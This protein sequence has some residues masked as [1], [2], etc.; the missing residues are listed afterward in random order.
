MNRTARVKA[1]RASEGKK[2]GSTFSRKLNENVL[3]ASS[4]GKS[5]KSSRKKPQNALALARALCV[6]ANG[7]LAQQ[8]AETPEEVRRQR[9]WWDAACDLLAA[10]GSR[11]ERTVADQVMDAVRGFSESQ[12]I[13]QACDR[14]A[15]QLGLA[16]RN[17]EA[18]APFLVERR[19]DDPPGLHRVQIDPATGRPQQAPYALLGR[20]QNVLA[21]VLDHPKI[22]F[23]RFARC[24]NEKCFAFYYKPRRSSQACSIR[25]EDVL[26][27]RAHYQ[28]EKERSQHIFKLYGQGESIFAIARI[29]KI[30]SGLVRKCLASKSQES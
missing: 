25:C 1:L 7:G 8:K 26:M 2:S 14:L 11:P 3:G 19:D 18:G 20:Y 24:S 16:L 9:Q 15:Q 5:Q 27:S 4:R 22:D 10:S 6:L 28:R 30:K 29:L 12:R 23:R 21:D 17:V 13:A